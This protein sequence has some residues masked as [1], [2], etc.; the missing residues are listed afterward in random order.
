[1]VILDILDDNLERIKNDSKAMEKLTSSK[2][3]VKL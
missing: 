2:V 3:C 1:M